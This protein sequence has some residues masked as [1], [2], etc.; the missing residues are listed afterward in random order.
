MSQQ[1]SLLKTTIKAGKGISRLGSQ[2]A[3]GAAGVGECMNE[4]MFFH[5]LRIHLY[6][7]P[8]D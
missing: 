6:S 2:I 3:G 1:L 8:A 5:I 7:K 4:G